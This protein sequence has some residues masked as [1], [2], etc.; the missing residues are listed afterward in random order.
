M[1]TK[2]KDIGQVYEKIPLWDNGTWTEVSF[3]SREAF[4]TS[5]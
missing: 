5:L 4:K 1:K 3:E 2:K